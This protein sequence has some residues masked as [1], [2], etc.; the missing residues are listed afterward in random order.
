MIVRF[1]GEEPQALALVKRYI[2]M[3]S[4]K[5]ERVSPQEGIMKTSLFNAFAE[6]LYRKV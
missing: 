4:F 3:F 2:K 1:V 5:E 6:E